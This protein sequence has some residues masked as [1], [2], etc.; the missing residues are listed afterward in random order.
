[1]TSTPAGTPEALMSFAL[2]G[3]LSKH[4]LASLLDAG[5][6]PAFLR[7]CASVERR[8][9]DECT[10]AADPC[11]ESGCSCEGEVCLQPILRAGSD[12]V[13]AC[14]AEWVKFF[15]DAHNRDRAWRRTAAE[16]EI[17]SL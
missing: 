5:A 3:R 6:R 10:S 11:L 7:A 15:A 4:A 12:Y 8:L 1:M 13:R 9:T 14:G 16:Y 2:E 17:E